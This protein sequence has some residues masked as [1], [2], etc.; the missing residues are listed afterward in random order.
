MPKTGPA[1]AGD[2]T[3][4]APTDVAPDLAA[5]EADAYQRAGHDQAAVNEPTETPGE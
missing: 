3:T 1:P 5:V 2:T 4:P